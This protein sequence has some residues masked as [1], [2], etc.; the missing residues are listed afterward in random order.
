[1]A[2]LDGLADRGALD[3]GAVRASIARPSGLAGIRRGRR[4]ASISRG[5]EEGLDPEGLAISALVN[6]LRPDPD[7]A[8][9]ASR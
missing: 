3:L 4:V 7:T 6:A 1:M 5:R 8:A 9:E 2:D